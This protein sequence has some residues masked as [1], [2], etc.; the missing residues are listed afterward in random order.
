MFLISAYSL[1]RSMNVFESSVTWLSVSLVV[2]GSSYIL[3]SIFSRLPNWTRQ[4]LVLISGFSFVLFTYMTIYLLPMYG[5]GLAGFIV[6]GISLHVFIP[7]LF[8]VNTVYLVKRAS[9]IQKNVWKSFLAGI[10]VPLLVG[11]VFIIKWGSLQKEINNV[12]ANQKAGSELP[13]WVYLAQRIPNTSLTE[14]M[15]KSGIVYAVPENIWD[16]ML[17]R[18]P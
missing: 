13:A 4:L 9:A 16:N 15:L 2:S 5:I 10:A 3:Y 17:W 11:L 6:F 14:K 7:L 12:Y 18:M 8:A 1:N